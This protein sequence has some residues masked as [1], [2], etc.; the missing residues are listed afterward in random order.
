MRQGALSYPSCNC[1]NLYISEYY[2][3]KKNVWI[4]RVSGHPHWNGPVPY[5][6][7]QCAHPCGSGQFIHCAH[8]IRSIPLRYFPL[9]SFAPFISLT[10]A[11][12]HKRNSFSHKRKQP[13]S[14][15]AIRLM[16]TLHNPNRH[17]HEQL[18]SGNANSFHSFIRFT[19][20]CHP[21]NAFWPSY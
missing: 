21:R 5:R 1:R 20:F 10:F 19:C 4:I 7:Q 6:L 16:L 2:L 13:Q 15:Y 17:Q 11:T 18:H 8:S 14:H 9:H 12:A 3:R